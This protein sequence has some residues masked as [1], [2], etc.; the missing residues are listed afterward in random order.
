M[1]KMGQMPKSMHD[2]ECSE[3]CKLWYYGMIASCRMYIS[4]IIGSLLGRLSLPKSTHEQHRASRRLQRLGFKVWDLRCRFSRLTNL[5]CRK[6]VWELW[7]L[8]L[9]WLGV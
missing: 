5:S 4:T 8:D 6:V 3:L 2:P 7:R 9:L 1:T